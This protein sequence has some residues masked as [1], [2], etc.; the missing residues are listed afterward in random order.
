LAGISKCRFE[1]D[2]NAKSLCGLDIPLVTISHPDS[3]NN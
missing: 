3:A 1:I 2:T